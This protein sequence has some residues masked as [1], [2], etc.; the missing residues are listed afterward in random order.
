MKKKKYYLSPIEIGYVEKKKGLTKTKIMIVFLVIALSFPTYAFFG[1][2]GGI[3]LGPLIAVA[4][5]ILETSRTIDQT[6]SNIERLENTVI[7]RLERIRNTF[8]KYTNIH[9]DLLRRINDTIYRVDNMYNKANLV[10]SERFWKNYGY[11]YGGLDE[12]IRYLDMVDV[13]EKGRIVRAKGGKASDQ[14]VDLFT[15]ILTGGLQPEIFSKKELRKILLTDKNAQIGFAQIKLKRTTLKK[16]VSKA[17]VTQATMKRLEHQSDKIVEEIHNG[18]EAG[19]LE[20]RKAELIAIQNKMIAKLSEQIA[21]L[22]KVNAILAG[23]YLHKQEEN[24][25]TDLEAYEALKK[26]KPANYK[27]Y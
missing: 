8:Y 5:Q 7:G 24:F 19:D 13:D 10:F 3:S 1:G 2:G 11:G 21:E 4:K 20:Q 26:R 22:T 17:V 12:I 16:A 27:G 9:N 14:N 15:D 25:K 23:Y 18:V 6:L